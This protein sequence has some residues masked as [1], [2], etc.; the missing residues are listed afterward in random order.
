MTD[1]T[2]AAGLEAWVKLGSANSFENWRAVALAVA[3]IRQ[4][5]MR[6]AGINKPQGKKYA[7]AINAGLEEHGFR[8]MP[9]P[10]RTA[11][12]RLVDNLQEIELWRASV[13]DGEKWNH[14]HVLVRK[15]RRAFAPGRAV[16]P[17]ARHI[18]TSAQRY[19]AANPDQDTLR[20]IATELRENWT[21]DVF[22][23]ALVAYHAVLRPAPSAQKPARPAAAD[24]DAAAH[25]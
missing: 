14:P 6:T 10:V 17:R 9:Y 15:W 22:K 1:D 25:A 21:Q 11:C 23:L 20:R 19:H 12:C 4:Q 8:A 5:A 2:I 18:V 16:E 3:V 7:A 13:P 24:A